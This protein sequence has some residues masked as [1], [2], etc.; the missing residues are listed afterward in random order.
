MN[1]L[2]LLVL[3]VTLPLLLGGCGEEPVVETK[4]VEEKQQEVKEEVKPKEP[5]AEVKPELKGVS[6]EE[7][8]PREGLAY[9]KGSDAP[10]TGKVFGLY[11]NGQKWEDNYKDGKVDGLQVLWYES[12]QKES[13]IN[14]K[15][16]KKDGL[17]LG[18]HENGQKMA[19]LNSKDGKVEGL[20]THWHSNGSL[21]SQSN[22]KDGLLVEGSIKYW[23]S[24]GEPVDTYEEAEAE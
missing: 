20:Q 11:E 5:V 17:F 7:I 16:G 18:W 4:P 24:K 14:Y 23:N 19:E 2:R 21:K 12:G 13:E 22:Y 3:L 10:Y 1:P 6:V 9:V 8:E 15:D